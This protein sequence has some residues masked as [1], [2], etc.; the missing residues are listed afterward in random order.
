MA[1][2]KQQLLILSNEV[3]DKQY[4]FNRKWFAKI[5][6]AD[7]ENRISWCAYFSVFIVELFAQDFSK[8]FFFSFFVKS[9]HSFCDFCHLTIFSDIMNIS[10]TKIE[11]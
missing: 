7:F 3:K 6:T 10:A 5:R 2:T 9:Q 4:L 8:L 1:F 11:N